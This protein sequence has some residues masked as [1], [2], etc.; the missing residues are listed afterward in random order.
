MMI[1]L[2]NFLKSHYICTQLRQA[3]IRYCLQQ[4]TIK[5]LNKNNLRLVLIE[6]LN[7]IKSNI[8]SIRLEPIQADLN[9]PFYPHEVASSES[10]IRE[11]VGIYLLGK[12]AAIV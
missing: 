3:W 9:E 11:R 6:V 4:T 1:I 12:L 10:A 2:N 7:R 5:R 8:Q